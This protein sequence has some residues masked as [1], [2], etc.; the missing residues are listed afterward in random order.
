MNTDI[1]KTVKTIICDTADIPPEDIRPDSVM[2][3][4]LSLSSMELM[5][6]VNQVERTFALSIPEKELRKFLTVEDL[7]TYVEEHKK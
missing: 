1:L 4:D 6:V 3:D 7:V 2:M 5:A